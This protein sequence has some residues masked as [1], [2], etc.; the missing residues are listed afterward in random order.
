MPTFD[1][2]CEV[3]ETSWI[4]E[5]IIP[6]GQ[7]CVILA[8]AGVGKSLVVE[9][10]AVCAIHDIPFCG[11]TTVS[12][13]VLLIDQDTPQ[14]VLK[15]R[16]IRF[17]KALDQPKKHELFV[18]SMGNYYM[19]NNTLTKI[20]LKYPTARFVI[21]DSLHSICGKFDPNSTVDMNYL[22]NIKQDCLIDGRSILLNHHITQKVNYTVEDLMTGMTSS[23]S[24]GSSAV[25]QQADTYYI[26]GATAVDGK[27]ER[28]FIR[29][30]S[31]RVSIASKPLIL[32]MLQTESGGEKL[33][34][35]GSYE[36][37]LNTVE[38]D[39]IML[40]RELP[41]ERTI[42][43]VYEEMGHK[44]GEKAVRDTLEKLES[45]G[46]LMMSRHKSNLFRYK[47]P[48]N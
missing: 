31:K 17:A 45:K 46:R 24:M 1:F 20:I 10:L 47:L 36:P 42:K 3:E 39:T 5:S 30:V 4:V 22:A 11:F 18:E 7:L 14:D 38:L 21:I 9:S 43:E 40:F 32:R 26:I 23:L 34:Y 33:E 8:Q 35:E 19:S 41:K 29:P 48:G 27:T 28:I 2:N 12:G 25:I 44:H 37:D 6:A 13:D 16:L 15:K